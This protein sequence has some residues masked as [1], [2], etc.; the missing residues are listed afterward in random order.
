MTTLCLQDYTD[1]A[2]R[3]NTSEINRTVRHYAIR[4]GCT[5]EQAKKAA[6]EGMACASTAEGIRIGC[7]RAARLRHRDTHNERS[8]K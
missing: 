2:E 1:G 8:M 7:Q 5:Q 3:V 4:I 6:R